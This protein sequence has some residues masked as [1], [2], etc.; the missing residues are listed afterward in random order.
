MSE[1]PRVAEPAA[2]PY[3]PVQPRE[4]VAADR[5]PTPVQ[6]TETPREPS[7]EI[8]RHDAPAPSAPRETPP[9]STPVQSEPPRERA[10]TTLD[11]PLSAPQSSPASSSVASPHVA[12][13]TIAST[14][15][16][17]ARRESGDDTNGDGD[18][19]ERKSDNAA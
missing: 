17:P 11:L 16:T 3:A 18:S 2:T 7:A 13:P 19:S 9:V 12:P 8:K 15:P 4:P 14:P 5:P 1:L 10:Q 6:S